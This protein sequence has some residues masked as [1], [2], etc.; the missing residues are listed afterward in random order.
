MLWPLGSC[1]SITKEPSNKMWSLHQIVLPK[2]F[3][4]SQRKKRRKDPHHARSAITREEGWE[5]GLGESFG[6]WKSP[7]IYFQKGNIKS[8]EKR[9]TDI[10]KDHRQMSLF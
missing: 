1:T 2:V 4:F 3:F 5:L 9:R 8:E 10:E 7:C 6:G